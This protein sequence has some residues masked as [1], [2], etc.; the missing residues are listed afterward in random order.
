MSMVILLSSFY[1]SDGN[2]LCH[3]P[4]PEIL[5]DYVVVT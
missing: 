3:A 2:W 4:V 1:N 5:G